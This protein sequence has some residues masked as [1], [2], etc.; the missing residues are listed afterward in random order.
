M[1][2]FSKNYRIEN[3]EYLN[4]KV[5]CECGMKKLCASHIDR[6]RRSELHKKCLQFSGED[7]KYYRCE[8]GTVITLLKKKETRN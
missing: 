5:N 1:A 8:C 3:K 4:R 6:H 2:E 7:T